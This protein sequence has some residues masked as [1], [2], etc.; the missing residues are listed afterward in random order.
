[1]PNPTVT[2]QEMARWRAANAVD[3]VMERES[4]PEQDALLETYPMFYHKQD[5]FGRPIYIELLGRADSTKLLKIMDIDRLL[6]YHIFSW[7]RYHKCVQ[8]AGWMA[9]APHVMWGAPCP[10]L[11]AEAAGRCVG[12]TLAALQGASKQ[13]AAELLAS[14][15][16]FPCVSHHGTPAPLQWAGAMPHAAPA[17]GRSPRPPPFPRAP[18]GS[19]CLRAP[20]PAARRS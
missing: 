6:T 4:F 9:G 2:V 20:R 11:L 15:P 5:K 10:S 14:L 7:E 13:A 19:T 18:A 12:H 3:T 1:M 16:A 17:H 8:M